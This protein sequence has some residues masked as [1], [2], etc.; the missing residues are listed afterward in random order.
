M[1][2]FENRDQSSGLFG[3]K[4]DVRQSYVLRSDVRGA[5]CFAA[6]DRQRDF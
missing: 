3:Q 2:G 4:N 5:Y 1:E 6:K